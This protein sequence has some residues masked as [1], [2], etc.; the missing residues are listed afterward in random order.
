MA[1]N[2]VGKRGASYWSGDLSGRCSS[3]S[4]L[5]PTSARLH[6]PW[7]LRA[8]S[9]GQ[10]FGLRVLSGI[11]GSRG[12]ARYRPHGRDLTA[13]SQWRTRRGAL[14]AGRPRAREDE[15]GP[16]RR[17][18]HSRCSPHWS[19]ALAQPLAQQ[20]FSSWEP[21][22][23]SSTSL[24][25]RGG[26]DERSPVL[27]LPSATQC[28]RPAVV[29]RSTRRPNRGAGLQRG[30]ASGMAATRHRN[31]R[32]MTAAG[33]VWLRFSVVVTTLMLIRFPPLRSGAI[34]SRDHALAW[35]GP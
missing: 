4:S 5:Q 12:A 35:D 22:P 25:R 17:R 28:G 29:N 3:G 32:Y 10:H 8:R 14:A 19:G 31:R 6:Q 1:Y 23:A 18:G 33:A 30:R 13:V 9:C 15:R 7:R 11:R 24:A 27:A 21:L 34:A 20:R 26:Q 2:S 16:G